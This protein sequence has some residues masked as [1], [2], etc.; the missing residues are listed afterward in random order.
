M[1]Q[2]KEQLP[3]NEINPNDSIQILNYTNSPVPTSISTDQQIPYSIPSSVSG[4]Y[5]S[6]Q[7]TTFQNP[8]VP[9]FQ[10]MNSQYNPSQQ[11]SISETIKPFVLMPQ[12]T[13]LSSFTSPESTTIPTPQGICIPSCSPQSVN[14][15]ELLSQSSAVFPLQSYPQCHPTD[16]GGTTTI[17]D[18]PKSKELSNYFSQFQT[19]INSSNNSSTIPMFSVKNFPQMSP[20]A[21]PLGKLYVLFLFLI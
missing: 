5:S 4:L 19:Q 6:P 3:S 1:E 16:I 17:A 14:N 11:S 13:T 10:L 7:I 12:V 9:T 20:L 15:Q 2:I 8:S 21:Q 18:L